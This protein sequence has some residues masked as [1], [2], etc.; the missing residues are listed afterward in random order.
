MKKYD[1][2]KPILNCSVHFAAVLLFFERVAL[3]V[4]LFASA[5]GDDQFGAAVFI[6]IEA[7]GHDGEAGRARGLKERTDFLAVEQQF[8]LAARQMVV[9]RTAVVFSD[10]HVLH[11]HLAVVDIAER[12]HEACLAGTYA[13][14]LCARKHDARSVFVHHEKVVLGAFVFYVDARGGYQFFFSHKISYCLFFYYG[15]GVDVVVNIFCNGG[16]EALFFFHEG[17]V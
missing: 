10:I 6:Y 12:V 9:V 2:L 15:K 16:G 11:P 17:I 3:V 5:E 4:F 7:Q 1:I 14:N 13:F 8:A